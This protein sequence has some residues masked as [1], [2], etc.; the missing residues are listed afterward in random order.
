MVHNAWTPRPH[1]R[2][3][4]AI[5]IRKEC[6]RSHVHLPAYRVPYV[7]GDC[8]STSNKRENESSCFYGEVMLKVWEVSAWRL[9]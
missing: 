3:T 6:I 8:S 5:L 1:D 9:E 7:L 4:R 2:R